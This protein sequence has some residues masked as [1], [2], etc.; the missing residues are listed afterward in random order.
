VPQLEQSIVQQENALS[1]L[2]GR[3]PGPIARGT[4]IIELAAPVVPAGLPSD[5]LERRP[6]LRQ[7]ER[8]LMAA[9]ARIGAAK[10]LYYP[11]IPLTAAFGTASPKLSDL[12]TGPARIWSYA[13]A[14]TGPIFTAGSI[15]G[16]VYTAEG[17]QRETLANYQ[18]AV[19]TAFQETDDALIGVQKSGEARDAQKLQVD[20]LGRYALLSRRKYEG[21]YTSYLEVLDAERSLFNAELAYSQTLGAALLQQ[22][23]LLKA[24]GG[25]WVEVADKGA[26]QPRA[27]AASTPSV[28]P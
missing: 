26:I 19:Q 16:Q 11:S 10:A 27:D 13:G 8:A 23:A 22:V 15:A 17:V 7:A 6:D 24:L 9:N 4:T 5:L 14:I 20:A 12:F 18:R 2:V 28:F 25:G 21:G 3:N 1:V